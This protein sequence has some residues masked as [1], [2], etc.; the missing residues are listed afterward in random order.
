MVIN[1]ESGMRDIREEKCYCFM[2][3]A[4]IRLRQT[5]VERDDNVVFCPKKQV[6]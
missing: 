5:I 2:F 4:T 3:G 6:K 1:S